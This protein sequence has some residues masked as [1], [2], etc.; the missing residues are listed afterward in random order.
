MTR[1]PAISLILALGPGMV[2]YASTKA[3]APAPLWRDPFAD[4]SL[5]LVDA[6]RA[7]LVSADIVAN[8]N[9]LTLRWDKAL[10]E[11]SVPTTSDPGFEVQ[12]TSDNTSRQVSSISVLGKVVT[13][14]LSSAVSAT[15]WLTVSYD[16][17]SSNL[18]K[19]AVGNYA[20]DTS[21]SVSITL[22]PNSP[23]EFPTAEDGARSV[24]ENT[25]AR[26]NIGDPIAATDADSDGLTYSISGTDAAFFGVVATSGRLRTKTALDHESRDS[27]SFTLSVTDGKD[28]H[29]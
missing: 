15:D 24:D 11:D 14:T 16:I 18:L 26:R 8:G 1:F 28:V 3:V 17:P 22:D 4:R 9:D 5:H 20:A 19:D 6:V 7:A 25:P 12:D 2:R 27:Y 13:L 29:G 21:A 23:P 10:N